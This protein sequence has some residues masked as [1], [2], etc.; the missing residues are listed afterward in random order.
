ME[1]K[2][3][4]RKVRNKTSVK[5]DYVLL[6]VILLVAALLR[7]WKLGKVPFMHDEFSALFRLRFDNFHDLIQYGVSENDSHPAGV[8]VFLYYWTKLVGWNEFWVKLPFALMG[9]GSVYLIYVIGKQ[10]FNRKVG[11][12]SAAF[13]A[14]SQLTV[15]Y[16]QLAR[17]YAAGLFFV[18]LLT[19]FWNKILF[20]PK[21]PSVGTVIGFAV[22]ACLAALAHNFSAAQA[23][24]IFLTG[25]FYLKKERRKAYWLSGIGAIVL[26]SPH[27]PV[28]YQQTFVNGGIGGWLA[29]PDNDFIIQFL[30][31]SM[32]YAPLFMFAVGLII[33]LPLILGKWEKRRKPIRWAGIVWFLV[34]FALAFVYSLLREPIIQYSTMI[35]CYPFFVMVA[36]SL[37]RNNTMTKMQTVIAVAAILFI[38]A[39]SLIVNRQH[40][41]LMYHQGYDQIAQRMKQDSDS[42]PCIRFATFTESAKVPE[43]YQAK[44]NVTNRVIFDYDNDLSDMRQWLENGDSEQIGFGWTDYA[45]PVWETQAVAYYPWLIHENTWFTSRY[46]TLSRDSV[47]GAKPLL[48][49]LSHEPMPFV[50]MEWGKPLVLYGDSL[51]ADTDVVGI[52]ATLQAID[53]L[54]RCI[55]VMEIHDQATDSLLLWQGS[56]QGNAMA[57]G[58]HQL[59]NAV[60]FDEKHFPIHGKIIKTFLWNQDKGTMIVTKMD[61]YSTRFNTRLTGLYQPL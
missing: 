31:Y 46:L 18:L 16:S 11:L 6:G 7:L 47:P 50:E 42:I 10:W 4:L 57:P 58:P 28:F 30:R 40:Y 53:T 36:F 15:F 27:L 38:G 1:R 39:S 44:A 33:I 51:D 35:F 48:Q 12:L 8:Q 60:R 41:D 14:V 3:H 49:P 56:D 13:F 17:P 26:Y 2:H 25:L 37:F 54:S 20:D 55:L 59:V 29:R 61:Y 43:Y 23:G 52:T 22:S 5:L 9:I 34:I 19:Y 21:K 24:L 32:N 45:N